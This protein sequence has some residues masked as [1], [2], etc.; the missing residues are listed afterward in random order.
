[1]SKAFEV[2]FCQ[3]T[4]VQ[5]DDGDM[6]EE[7]F[8]D[9]DWR[10]TF[11]SVDCLEDVCEIIAHGF[12]IASKNY[13]SESNK[14]SCFIEGFGKFVKIDN[15][16]WEL[17]ESARVDCGNILITEDLPHQVDYVQEV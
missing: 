6:A 15:M 13:D 11:F 5:F 9:S 7:Y 14:M 12:N 17:C 3:C 10:N 8:I 1:M 4:V 2:N 16:N